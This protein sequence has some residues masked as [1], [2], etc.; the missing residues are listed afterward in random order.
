VGLKVKKSIWEWYEEPGNE[1]RLKRF[2]AA[3][4]GTTK[5]DPPNAIDLGFKWGSLAPGSVIVDVGGGLGHITMKLAQSYPDFN[6]I[7]QD[8]QSILEQGREV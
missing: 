2:N 8:R 6:Y 3:M 7:V 1:Y 5:L 4:S